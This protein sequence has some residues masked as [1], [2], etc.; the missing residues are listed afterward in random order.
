MFV[1]YLII[2][3]AHNLEFQHKIHLNIY[4]GLSW[5][6]VSL[7]HMLEINK[8]MRGCRN[9]IDSFSTTISQ[10]KL[11]SEVAGSNPWPAA[12]L[13]EVCLRLCEFHPAIPASSHSSETCTWGRLGPLNCPAVWVRVQ[14]APLCSAVIKWRL[15]QGG[16]PHSPRDNRDRPRQPPQRFA[17]EAVVENAWMEI[18]QQCFHLN[19]GPIW[20]SVAI[21]H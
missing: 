18:A 12:F 3:N 20:P 4:N 8:W 7:V 6:I 11:H 17:G 15:V 13:R 5:S 1:L 16:S 10:W 21:I 2:W 19:T 14:P 9:H